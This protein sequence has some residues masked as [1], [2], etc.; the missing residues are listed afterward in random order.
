MSQR[1]P[2]QRHACPQNP[3]AAPFPGKEAFDAGNFRGLKDG[4]D[5]ARHRA[6][7]A[8]LRKLCDRTAEAPLAAGQFAAL[9][10]RYSLQPRL[11]AAAAGHAPDQY[12]AGYSNGFQHGACSVWQWLCDVAAGLEQ[13]P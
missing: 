3:A 7:I 6:A 5:W 11:L 12:D 2:Q 1:D 13:I 4:A 10:D 8:D 9:L